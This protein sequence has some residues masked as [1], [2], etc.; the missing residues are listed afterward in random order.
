MGRP[1]LTID[2]ILS[3]AD[4]HQA[5]TSRW[6]GLDDGAVSESPGNSWRGIDRALRRGLRGLPGGSSLAQ[7]LGRERGA[8][9]HMALPALT[10]DQILAWA[11]A[12]R[13]HTA[14]WPRAGS[15]PVP[16][17]AGETWQNIDNAL[18]YG[19]RGLQGGSSLARLLD[20]ERGIPARRGRKRSPR[21]EQALRLRQQGLTLEEVGRR[22]GVSRQAVWQMLRRQ[23]RRDP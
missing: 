1:T 5:R 14:S 19:L 11:D 23:G 18:R 6:P 16:Q 8:R 10:E 2:E 7:L 4:A 12:H 22:L 13:R 3:W 20:R 21:A 17:A 9:N 15:G